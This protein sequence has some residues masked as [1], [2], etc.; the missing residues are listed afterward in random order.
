MKVVG[1]GRESS[2]SSWEE[3]KRGKGRGKAIEV[4]FN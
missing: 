4:Y 2:E 1:H 3:L